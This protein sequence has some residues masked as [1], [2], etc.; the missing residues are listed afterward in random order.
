MRIS[1]M[2][3]NRNS[4]LAEGVEMAQQDGS[5]AVERWAPVAG[6]VAAGAGLALG[7]T[8]V[9][10]GTAQAQDFTVSNTD[11][12]G[13]GSLR[14][15]IEDANNN[16]G[17][18][19]VV[20]QSDVSGT[21]HLNDPFTADPAT[22]YAL[23]ITD[24]LDI[25]GP[26]ADRVTVSADARSRV[27]YVRPSIDPQDPTANDVSISGLKIIQGDISECAYD[28]CNTF[29]TGGDIYSDDAD[30]TISSSVI[31]TGAALF[32]GGIT[33]KYGT[34][35]M[36]NSTVSGNTA[37]IAA[38]GIY[39]GTNPTEYEPATT[40]AQTDQQP[41]QPS[42]ISGSTINNN[43]GGTK[44]GFA[45]NSSTPPPPDATQPSP[46]SVGAGGVS[47][48]SSLTIENS[49]FNRNAT[50]GQGGA[51]AAFSSTQ[52]RNNGSRVP[53]AGQLT[54]R[55]STISGN[56]AG[57]G[58]GV[59][60]YGYTAR[61]DTGA[62]YPTGAP[63][64]VID[65]SIV[66]HNDADGQQNGNDLAGAKG[67]ED[68]P[69]PPPSGNHDSATLSA[70]VFDTAFSLIK[71][72]T[73]VVINETVP[74]SNIT[75]QDPQLG[76]LNDNGGATQTMALLPGSPAIDHGRTPG[77]ETTDQ[78]GQTRPFDLPQI[79]NSA[80][81]G[82]DGADMGA[83]EVQGAVP[84]GTCEGK[85]AT[86][87][88]TENRDVLTGTA[89]DDVIVAFGGNDI[90]KA[91][92]GNDLVC[93]GDG[94]DQVTGGLGNDRLKGEGGKDRMT[95]QAGNDTVLDDAGDDQLNGGVGN[96]TVKGGAG[97]DRVLGSKGNDRLFGQAADDVILG[98][99]GND[100]L[101]GG[102][103]NDRLSGGVGVNDVQQ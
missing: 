40:A 74:G 72:T 64:P 61:D 84:T 21:I 70:A 50:P 62:L 80:A 31:R 77:G 45:Y 75:G 37:T 71:D 30:L 69:P 86:I 14:Q 47:T 22:N 51:I 73:G 23:R 46:R 7:V 36:H 33:E 13:P 48:E 56:S 67:T 88:G 98:A 1:P 38:G 99:K 49:T 59:Y 85:P 8:L 76:A 54:L 101:R 58:G 2:E 97:Q 100:F 57:S 27:F 60:W 19:R 87:S 4:R 79:G 39:I 91:L 16:A 15:A 32:G 78:R 43:F 44:Y 68:P 94:Q 89:G 25:V 92:Q 81:P 34:L 103:G 53:G 6:R 42:V 12:A 41:V 3:S 65:N 82:A 24:A 11:Q 66:A 102:P 18:D 20:F 90:I 9:T 29:P 35:T 26:G 10:G 52:P 5:E 83:F 63:N 96:D 93:A 17:P 28:S 95:G 55:S